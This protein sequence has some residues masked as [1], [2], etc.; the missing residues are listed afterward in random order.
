M[1]QLLQSAVTAMPLASYQKLNKF[2]THLG[3]WAQY[4]TSVLHGLVLSRASTSL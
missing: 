2:V 1:S 3:A 4:G